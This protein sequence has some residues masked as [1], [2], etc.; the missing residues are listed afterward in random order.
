[1]YTLL[2]FD[3]DILDFMCIKYI[4]RIGRNQAAVFVFY[5]T[6]IVSGQ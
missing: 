6:T 5:H 1:M 3:R 2:M 4:A